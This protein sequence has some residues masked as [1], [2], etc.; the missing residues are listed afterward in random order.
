MEK[1]T[2]NTKQKSDYIE[3]VGRRKEATARVRIFEASRA[4]F[5]INGERDLD[6]YFPSRD[7][8][9]RASSPLNNLKLPVKFKV[10][11]KIQGGGVSAQA[12]ALRLGL[13]RGLLKYDKSLRPQLKKLGYLTRNPRVKERRKFGLKKARKAAQWSKR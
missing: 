4:G 8:R 1:E 3:A 13:S 11:A 2:T 12:E 5:L 10:T 7:L 6:N 9:D